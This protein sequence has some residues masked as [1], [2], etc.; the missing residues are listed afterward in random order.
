M[1]LWI[2]TTLPALKELSRYMY[3]IIYMYIHVLNLYM[4]NVYTVYW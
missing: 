3:N 4:Y 1:S 2:P